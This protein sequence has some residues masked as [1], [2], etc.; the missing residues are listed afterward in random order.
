LL[1][2]AMP[3]I[4]MQ[5]TD[6]CLSVNLLFRRGCRFS[7]GS[8]SRL[9]IWDVDS[10]CNTLVNFEA[11]RLHAGKPLQLAVTDDPSLVFVPCMGSIKVCYFS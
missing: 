4:S 2:V 7:S 3:E 1:L 11:M 10:G 6:E 5:R 8:D 9:R